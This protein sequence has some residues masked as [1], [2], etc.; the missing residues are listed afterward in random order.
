MKKKVQI[1]QHAP[2]KQIDVKL[3]TKLLLLI[4]TACLKLIKSAKLLSGVLF[5]YVIFFTNALFYW[6]AITN[7]AD[8]NICISMSVFSIIFYLVIQLVKRDEQNVSETG[9]EG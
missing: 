2:E 5:V 7:K 6:Y 9:E 1:K 3:A 4:E 8:L